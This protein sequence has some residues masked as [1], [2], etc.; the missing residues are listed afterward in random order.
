[1]IFFQFKSFSFINHAIKQ[2][3]KYIKSKGKFYIVNITNKTFWKNT[4][5]GQEILEFFKGMTNSQTIEFLGL[6]DIFVVGF[7][8]GMNAYVSMTANQ[9]SQKFE[10]TLCVS[11][12]KGYKQFT[13][14]CSGQATPS[15]ED[16]LRGSIGSSPVQPVESS[17]SPAGFQQCFPTFGKG[18]AQH[19]VSQAF[20]GLREPTSG[21]LPFNTQPPS[22]GIFQPIAQGCSTDPFTR[23]ANFIP[24]ELTN[25][26]ISRQGPRLE[27]RKGRVVPVEIPSGC[28]SGPSTSSTVGIAIS[29]K[30]RTPVSISITI[31]NLEKKIARLERLNP[32]KGS[33][34]YLELVISKAKLEK[35][36]KIRNSL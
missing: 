14:R 28:S 5:R 18:P 10:K 30:A 6:F 7:H 4:P 3:V 31:A 23:Q 2:I 22:L 27:I 15:I 26:P 20:H 34:D 29:P 8:N 17:T 13:E 32:A 33:S 9:S 11:I 25:E 21:F 19:Q 36:R 1:M 16:D 35:I 24:V 12:S